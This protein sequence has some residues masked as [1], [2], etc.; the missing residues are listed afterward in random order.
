MITLFLVISSKKSR[1]R[2]SDLNYTRTLYIRK[3]EIDG[4]KLTGL[5]KPLYYLRQE[6]LRDCF[7]VEPLKYLGKQVVNPS[8]PSSV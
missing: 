5:T 3:T 7:R 4:K 1:T 8:G 6:S 2:S